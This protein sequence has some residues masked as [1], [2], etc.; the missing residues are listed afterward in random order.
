MNFI[1]WSVSAQDVVHFKAVGHST[2]VWGCSED[3][4]PCFL[5]SDNEHMGEPTGSVEGANHCN[6]WQAIL[7]IAS[8]RVR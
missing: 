1:T 4:L 8:R 3:G 5:G 6:K 2:M 7:A